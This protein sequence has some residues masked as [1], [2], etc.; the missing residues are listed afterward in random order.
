[1]STPLVPWLVDLPKGVLT[2]HHERHPWIVDRGPDTR[3]REEGVTGLSSPSPISPTPARHPILS[4]RYCRASCRLLC[5]VPDARLLCTD[6]PPATSLTP[7]I[8]F[9]SKLIKRGVGWAF[10]P[11][12]KATSLRKQRVMK[13]VILLFLSK[14]TGPVTLS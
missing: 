8:R 1:M 4:L 14:L 11:Y 7:P 9:R 6:V 5:R 3:S 10:P 13:K 2:E 12:S